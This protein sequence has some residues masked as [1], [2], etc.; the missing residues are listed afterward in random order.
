MGLPLDL[1]TGA[2]RQRFRQSNA[3]CNK[4][5]P[6][7]RLRSRMDKHN[8]PTTFGVFKPVGHSVISFRTQEELRSATQALADMGFAPSAMVEYS[9]QE[10]LVLATAELQAAGSLAN[11]GYELDLLKVRHG[12]AEQGCSFLI[13]HAPDDVQA[14]RV[15]SLVSS[16]QPV[17]AQHYGRFLIQDLTEPKMGRM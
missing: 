17:G 7:Q 5:L 14:A 2:A 15:A 1:L 4:N 6:H 9:P 13:V 3:S 12:L 8:P 10:M 16:M 11:F